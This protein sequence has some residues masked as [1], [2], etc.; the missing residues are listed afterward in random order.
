[1]RAAY[2][3][4]GQP[5]GER[6]GSGSYGASSHGGSSGGAGVGVCLLMDPEVRAAMGVRLYSFKV[7]GMLATFL[8]C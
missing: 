2:P 7:C 4:S 1:M 8:G 6:G 5:I 3:G